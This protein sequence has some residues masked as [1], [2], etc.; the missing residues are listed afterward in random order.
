M[1]NTD[2]FTG[3]GSGTGF[4]SWTGAGCIA[5]R[6]QSSLPANEIAAAW[7]LELAIRPRPADQ[8]TTGRRRR[9]ARPATAAWGPGGIPNSR[10]HIR[11]WSDASLGRATAGFFIAWPALVGISGPS[12]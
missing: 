3:S 8:P 11:I 7:D 2:R 4:S 9:S 12:A 1:V 10:I 5:F 6:G